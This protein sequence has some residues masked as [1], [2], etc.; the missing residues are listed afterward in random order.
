MNVNPVPLDAVLH[1][2]DNC[3]CLSAQRAAR[4]LARRFDLAFQRFGITNQQFSLMMALLAPQ[5]PLISQLAPFLAMDRT[6]LTAALKALE[7]KGLAMT[8]VDAKDRR[9]KRPR[10]TEAGHVTLAEAL[11]VWCSEH[12]RLEAELSAID[13][14]QLRASLAAIR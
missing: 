2:R 4:R 6:T 7:R 10:L 1:V 14:D 11:P 8:V 3:L 9:G 13:A 12:A 5:P